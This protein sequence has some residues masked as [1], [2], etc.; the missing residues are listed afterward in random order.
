ME[1]RLEL[2]ADGIVFGEG[3]RWHA[4]RLFFSD[5]KD[6]AVKAV[7]PGR[8]LETVVRLP[9]EPSGLG[10]L[11]DGRLLVVSMEDHRLLRLD[12]GGLSEV[13]D[14]SPHCGG[15][16]NDMVVDAHGRAYIGNIGFDLEAQP[17]APRPTNLVRV[18]PDGAVHVAAREIWCPNG[19]AITA[20]GSTLVAAESAAGRLTAFDVA[21]DGAL[22]RQRVFATLPQGAAPDGICVDAEDAVWVA[23]PTTREFL[24][25]RDGGELA[26][27]IP[28]GERIAIACALGGP[29][30][31]TL[32]LV[33]SQTMSLAE[34]VRSRGGRIEACEVAVPGAGWP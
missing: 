18:D 15:R 5:I 25:V 21:S 3:P 11:P 19:L 33:T 6:H 34:A 2:V 30:R 9:G 31:R 17:I 32:F 12:A 10:W 28:T 1:R 13:A 8:K 14:L 22:S 7:G 26:E 27:R 29:G 24:R 16:A 4:G 20:D 23:S